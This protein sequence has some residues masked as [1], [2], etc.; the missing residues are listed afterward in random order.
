MG[1][2]NGSLCKI[3]VPS[4]DVLLKKPKKIR[5]YAAG[6]TIQSIQ[7]IKINS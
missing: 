4:S 3:T 7:S 6:K 2:Q 5:D 1:T